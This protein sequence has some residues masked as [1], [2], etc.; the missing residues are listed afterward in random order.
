MKARSF[1]R[2]EEESVDRVIREVARE[3]S[4]GEHERDEVRSIGWEAFLSVYYAS[5]DSFSWGRTEGWRQAYVQIRAA[6]SAFKTQNN[7]KYY[8]ASLDQPVIWESDTPR[9]SML[10]VRHGDFVPYLCLCDFISR[11]PKDQR[12]LARAFKRGYEAEEI[13][14]LFRCDREKL[15]KTHSRL[16]ESMEN[17]LNI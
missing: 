7:E 9:I 4:L 8:T 5:P 17:Y 10:P 12:W 14:E 2:R 11:L 3:L 6:L 13:P 1:S 15:R 16:R